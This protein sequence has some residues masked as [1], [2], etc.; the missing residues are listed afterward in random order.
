MKSVKCAQCGFVGWADSENCKKCGAS[1]ESNNTGASRQP[2]PSY[3][4]YQSSYAQYPSGDR[5]YSDTKLHNGMAV[6]SMV[7][8]ILGLPTFGLLGVGAITGIT[9]SIIALSNAKRSPQE[10]G[11]KGMA[12]TG[13]VTSIVSLMII[14]FAIVMAIAVPNLVASRRAANE[15]SSIATL[16][17]IH[18]AQ[19][20]YQATR[21]NGSFGTLD[22]LVADGL[23]NPELRSGS[24][25]GYKFTV[26]IKPTGFDGMPGFEAIGVPIT[27]GNT[28]RR[29][30]YVDES[31][32]IRAGDNR[33]AE[34]TEL[35][36]PLDTNGYSSSSP[37]SRYGYE[38]RDQ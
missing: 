2:Q 37:P 1:R 5:G 11:G 28:G 15:G 23:I 21:G 34:A 36:D 19:A 25:H 38:P 24:R 7:L 13:L 9:L 22:Q 33:G 14:P 31:G 16:R 4:Q 27:Y 8:G 10:Y 18:S 26:D 35:D 29:S 20:T 12:I 17:T 3:A 32:V 6:T 30:F